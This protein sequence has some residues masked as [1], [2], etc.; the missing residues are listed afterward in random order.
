MKPTGA[1]VSAFQVSPTN[2]VSV[3]SLMS[4]STKHLTAGAIALGLSLFVAVASSQAQSNFYWDGSVAV[5]NWADANNWFTTNSA[6]NFAT[7]FDWPGDPSNPNDAN[8]Q[9][10]FAWFTN[11]GTFNVSLAGPTTFIDNS[12]VFANAS[13]TVQN[14][15][16][17]IAAGHTFLPGGQDCIVVGQNAGATSIVSITTSSGG[18]FNPGGLGGTV[19]VGKN[20]YGT[21]LVTNQTVVNYVGATF[22]LGGGTNS[23]GVLIIANPGTVVNMGTTSGGH[24]N[25]GGGNSSGNTLILSNFARLNCPNLRV[26]CTS[27]SGSSNNVMIVD[28]GA[29]LFIA[30]GHAVV[31]M[32][33]GDTAGTN[34]PAYNNTLIFQN[35]GYGDSS[36]HTFSIGWADNDVPTTPPSTGNV[37]IVQAGSALTNMSH[38]F[39]CS[40]NAAFVYGGVFGG[41]YGTNA[42]AQFTYNPF[43]GDITNQGSLTCW[44]TIQGTVATASGGVMIVSNNVGALTVTHDFSMLT[45]SVLQV[46]LGSSFNTIAAGS[47]VT[48]N[49]KINFIDS[50]GFNTVGNHT[51]TLFTGNFSTNFI[52]GTTTSTVPYYANTNNLTIGTVPNPSA[53]YTISLPDFNTVNLI[54]SGLATPLPFQITSITKSGNDVVINWNTKGSNGQF[55]YVQAAPGGNYNTNSFFDIATNTIAGTTASYTDP[56]GATNKPNRYYRVR[57]PQ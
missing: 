48:L 12:N 32:R 27:G 56:S 55:N 16:I 14:V 2:P 9:A 38:C 46:S 11:S 47:N 53:T 39:I 17:N 26:G 6:G 24:L 15:S 30:G 8:Y 45:G 5:G 31:G 20:G 44:G 4:R 41:G 54:V 7:G 29:E 10:D 36:N 19:R 43:G 49:G 52:S 34:T 42:A 23:Q 18:T 21:F 13:G 28:S 35:Q 22:T 57:S 25:V 40:N 50:G 3:F 37:C 1:A 51:Y 33:E